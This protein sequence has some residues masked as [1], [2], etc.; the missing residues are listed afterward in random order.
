MASLGMQ[1]NM[2]S[3]G[4]QGYI[5]S[6]KL[7]DATEISG[8]IRVNNFVPKLEKFITHRDMAEYELPR[9]NKNYRDK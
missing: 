4:M 8:K 1:C 9:Y 6:E 5:A 3:L 2:A 7:W